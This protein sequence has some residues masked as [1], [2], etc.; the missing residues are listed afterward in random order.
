MG[1]LDDDT[2]LSVLSKQYG[3]PSVNLFEVKVSPEILR[4]L[5]FEKIKTFKVLPLRKIDDTLSLAMVDPNN[6]SVIQEIEFVLGRIVKPLV[7]PEYQMDEVINQFEKEGYG[8]KT[9]NGERLKEEAVAIESKIPNIYTLLRSV[10]QYKATDLHL[11]AGAPPSVRV[12]NEL[13]R[14]SMSAV[15][16]AQLRDFVSEI[17]T[18][19]Q[20]DK[21]EREKEIEFTLSLPDIGRF[22][23]NMYK[24]RG[25]ISIV[26]RLIIENIPSLKELNLPEWIKDYALRPQGFILIVGPAG[27][28]TTTT[29]AALVDVINSNR[30]CNIVTLESPIEYLHK[31]KKSNVNQREVSVDTVSFVSGLRHIL[32]QDPDV[33]VI[34]ELTDPE[35]VSIV[36]TAAETGHLV[37]STMHSLNTTTAISRLIDLFPDHQQPQIR[38]QF[39][40]SFLLVFAQR[41]VPVKE[42]EGRILA[43]EKLINT[44]KTRNL[45]RE[46]KIPRMRSLMEIVSEDMSSIDQSLA[47]L[48]LEG[49][50]T[51]ED[52]LKF[53]D[54][55][56]YYQE[57]IRARKTEEKR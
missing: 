20:M 33:I 17:L 36:L 35:S 39:A 47:E 3:L 48:C 32:K 41:L 8:N 19:E 38:R 57:I 45:I 37:I 29:M 11:T 22:R 28:G 7:A 27:H 9:F 4:L 42:G 44:I 24:Q 1:Y 55:Q 18:K 16:P 21:L 51:F 23:I 56:V 15:T 12:N 6:I 43:Y 2:L 40:D 46:G 52:G 13:K 14:I 25:S 5:P 49:K 50:I 31:H 34:G 10:L 26:A 30:R 53:A 54:N